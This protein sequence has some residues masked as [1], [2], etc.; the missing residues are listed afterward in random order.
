M[1]MT[2]N[3]I[4]Y[5]IY[6]INSAIT[7]QEFL[8]LTTGTLARQSALTEVKPSFDSLL[9]LSLWANYVLS[10]GLSFLIHKTGMMII[11]H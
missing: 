3:N 10:C 2:K 6:I 11:T 9:V 8:T 1:D 7:S 5:L 4:L